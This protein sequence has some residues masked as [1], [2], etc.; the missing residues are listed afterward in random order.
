M[1]SG[2]SKMGCSREAV[3][4]FKEMRMK[5]CEPNEMSVVSVL[6]ACGDLGD[7][8]FGKLLEGL[9]EEKGFEL[10]TFVGSSLINMF[11]KVE[12]RSLSYHVSF[13]GCVKCRE[14]SLQIFNH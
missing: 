12:P 6:G 2:Y 3:G 14:S 4:L 5:G 13:A 9:I 8:S 10:N 1:I 7:L 11:G